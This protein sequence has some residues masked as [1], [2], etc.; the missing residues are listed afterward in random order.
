MRLI[1][2]AVVVFTIV[3]V[4]YVMVSM[5]I[6]RT[7]LKEEL[8]V[9]R[10]ELAVLIDQPQTVW[11][12]QHLLQRLDCPRYD[13]GTDGVDGVP[14]PN[15]LGAWKNYSFDQMANEPEFMQAVLDWK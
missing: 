13:I 8:Q 4:L 7:G 2:Q 3:I 12:V 14:G 5:N 9:A 6:E 10:C 1:F 11:E 15:T